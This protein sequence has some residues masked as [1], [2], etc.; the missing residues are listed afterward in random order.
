M[1]GGGERCEGYKCRGGRGGGICGWGQ[2]RKVLWK[3]LK[4]FRLGGILKALRGRID[5]LI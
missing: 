1:R 5:N 4:S 3:F 2:S